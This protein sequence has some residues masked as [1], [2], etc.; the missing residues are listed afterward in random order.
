MRTI[1]V[2]VDASPQHTAVLEQAAKQA[3]QSDAAVHVVSVVHPDGGWTA[4]L[5]GEFATVSQG[6]QEQAR[7]VLA[8]SCSELGGM[9]ISCTTHAAVGPVAQEISRLAAMIGADLIVIGH[10]NLSWLDRW[11]ENSVG[12]ELLSYPPC[13]ILIVVDEKDEGD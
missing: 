5:A 4:A 8:Q 6:L 11:V 2:A 13:N 10:R 1:L 3:V 12:K 9:G 7:A